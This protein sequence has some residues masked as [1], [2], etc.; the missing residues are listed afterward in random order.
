MAGHCVPILGYLAM[1]DDWFDEHMF[2]VAINRKYLPDEILDI[3]KQ[4]PIELPAWDPMG[5]LA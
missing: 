3:L 5:A 1:T 2:E 4:E